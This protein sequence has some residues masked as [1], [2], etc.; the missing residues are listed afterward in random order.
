MY[1]L[2][3]HIYIYI[4]IYNLVTNKLGRAP[5]GKRLK[6]IIF[7]DLSRPVEQSKHAWLVP[8]HKRAMLFRDWSYHLLLYPLFL[9]FLLLLLLVLLFLFLLPA[10]SSSSPASSHLG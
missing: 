2:R 5:K 9:L 1:T 4:Y 10:S 7:K 3:K 8:L 6:S